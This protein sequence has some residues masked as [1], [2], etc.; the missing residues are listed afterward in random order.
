MRNLRI[1]T[2][3]LLISVVTVLAAA[4]VY[5]YYSTVPGIVQVYVSDP[6]NYS[7]D[8]QHIYL[9]FYKV[10]IHKVQG[11][12]WFQVGSS[13][14]PTIDLMAAINSSVLLSFQQIPQGSYNMVRLTL[15]YAKV[16]LVQNGTTT[17]YLLA[18]PP[19]LLNGLKIP[20]QGTVNSKA[21]VVGGVIIDITANDRDLHQSIL[22]PTIL[23]LVKS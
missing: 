10:E 12:Q 14:F 22:T 4:S 20:L 3:A 18:I 1:K 23:A 2:F 16:V 15:S 7:P 11:D 19:D 21:G 6:P 17:S 8:V 13:F 9:T 5:A